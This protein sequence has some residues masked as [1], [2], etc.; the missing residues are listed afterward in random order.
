MVAPVE[1]ERSIRAEIEVATVLLGFLFVVI[2][3]LITM[4]N[5]VLD[6]LKII[7]LRNFLGIRWFPFIDAISIIAFYCSVF[8]LT[9]IPFYLLYVSVRKPWILPIARTF[10]G[11]GI[12]LT[13]ILTLL[14]NGI[15]LFR[16]LGKKGETYLNPAFGIVYAVASIAIIIYIVALWAKSLASFP[17]L[18][19]RVRRVSAHLCALKYSKETFQN[20]VFTAIWILLLLLIPL[21]FLLPSIDFFFKPLFGWTLYGWLILFLTLETLLW[22]ALKLSKRIPKKKG[23]KSVIQSFI[24]IV[25]AFLVFVGFKKRESLTEIT[26]GIVVGILLVTGTVFSR[27]YFESLSIFLTNPLVVLYL[28]FTRLEIWSTLILIPLIEEII[29][30]GLFI[31]RVM[32]VFSSNRLFPRAIA[33]IS[34]SVIFGWTHLELPVYK[35]LAGLVLGTVYMW[36]WRNNILATTAAHISGNF[37]FFFLTLQ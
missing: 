1:S 28:L 17:T 31:N 3:V 15:F 14:F 25:K 29:Y 9:S 18:Q 23:L 26:A 30:R 5:D 11:I 34:S 24:D 32:D 6:E 33:I 4:P 13:V 20:I 16:L 12:Y 36:G 35:A 21:D 8:L 2:S 10:L 22:W 7:G 27:A 19:Q 37:L